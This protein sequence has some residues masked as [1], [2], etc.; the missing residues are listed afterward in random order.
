MLYTNKKRLNAQKFIITDKLLQDMFNE[1]NKLYFNN[2]IKAI[3]LEII[4]DFNS[5]GNFVYTINN[6][7]YT[8]TNYKIQISNARKRSKTAYITTL[9]HE[10][11]HYMVIS[12][13]STLIIKQALWYDLNGNNDMSDKLLYNNKYAHTGDWLKLANNIN[14]LYGIKIN[15][16]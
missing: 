11:L 13:L 8:I 9:I 6:S 5:N 3:P 1:C 16:N 12:K 2:N 4:T 14:K 7:N 10:I 15:R